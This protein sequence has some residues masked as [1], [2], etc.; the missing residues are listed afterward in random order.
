VRNAVARCTAIVNSSRTFVIPTALNSLGISDAEFAVLTDRPSRHHGVLKW[1]VAL[2]QR[3]A[4]LTGYL[5][6]MNMNIQSSST[7]AP[8]HDVLMD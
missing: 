3:R 5:H 1:S 8:P 7:S 6:N 4:E 2:L